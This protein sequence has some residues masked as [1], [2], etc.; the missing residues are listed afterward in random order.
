MTA[1]AELVAATNFSFLR[2]ASHAHEMVGQAAELGL[3]AIGIADRNTLAG[4]VRAHPAAKEHNIRACASRR[5]PRHHR[6]LRGGLLSDRPRRLRPAVPPADRRQPPRRQG[7]VPVHLRGDAGRE[8]GADLHRHARRGGS[9]R[10]SPSACARSPR[11]AGPRLS[12]RHLRLRGDERRRLGELAALAPAR[13]ARSSPPTTPPITSPTAGR[14][15]TCSPASARSARFPRPAT[16]WR[17]T[18]SATSRAPPRWRACSPLP[19]GRRPL[20]RDHP[21]DTESVNA[22]ARDLMGPVLGAERTEAAIRRFN[23]LER[24]DDVAELSAQS[25]R[26]RRES[27][28]S[29]LGEVSSPRARSRAIRFCAAGER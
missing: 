15:P 19:A 16:A 13:A 20:A 23:E 5:A 27:S 11:R 18:P 4:V 26:S 1:F 6:R 14:S 24:V 10:P 7:P 9:R 21:L 8:R 17:P 22:K 3:A 29:I 12:R 2:G 25:W 28:P